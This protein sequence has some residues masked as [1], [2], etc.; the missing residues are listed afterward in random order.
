LTVRDVL[1]KAVAGLVPAIR[2]L[3]SGIDALAGSRGHRAIACRC[4]LACDGIAAAN[5]VPICAQGRLSC[6]ACVIRSIAYIAYERRHQRRFCFGGGA[7][8]RKE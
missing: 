8:A 4:R 3:Q 5:K 1:A 6:G 2:F 7:A